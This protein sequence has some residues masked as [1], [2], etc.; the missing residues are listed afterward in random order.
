[1]L[2]ERE[3][4]ETD[5]RL[6]TLALDST[7]PRKARM[8]AL[9]TRI[10]RSTADPKLV[11]ALLND[12]DPGFRA[13]G[14]RAA[15]NARKV[16]PVLRDKVMSLAGDASPDVQIQV[17]IAARKIEGIEP[18]SLLAEV[19]SACG[20][21]PLIPQIVWQNLHPLLAT[22]SAVFLAALDNAGARPG[23]G[24]VAIL[25]RALDR[26][27]QRPTPDAK[28]VTGLLARLIASRNADAARQGILAL[29]SRLRVKTVPEVT[30]K[31]IVGGLT[32]AASGVMNRGAGDPVARE[33]FILYATVGENNG[34]AASLAYVRD[35]G[36][37]DDVRI[38]AFEA[39]VFDSLPPF[40]RDLTGDLLDPEKKAG[41]A[42]FR[43]RL[44][45][46][47][48]SRD[49]PELATIVLKHYPK[50]E[51]VLKPRAVELLT[52]RPAWG[53]ALLK[54]IGEGKVDPNA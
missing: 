25:P 5:A 12:P 47:I 27:L 46:A 9:W 1:L 13:W 33:L 41:S 34:V 22:D 35:P 45:A 37:P 16:E 43:G 44:L 49:D 28:A 31:E 24:L 51:P 17:A 10:S 26:L 6:R 20:D 39:L 19:A 38:R 18:V 23:P 54:A 7:A 4:S 3:G 2:A 11:K 14:V 52:Q 32:K 29:T 8:N 21:D 50:M 53:R 15:G 30:V 42:E 40:A 36:M 48:G